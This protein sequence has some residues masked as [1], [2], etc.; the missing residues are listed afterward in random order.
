MQF[1]WKHIDDIL[2]KGFSIIDLL[3][4]ISYF[5]VTQIPMALPIAIGILAA[6]AAACVLVLVMRRRAP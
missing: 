5:A 3:E 4:L 6:V 1:L 2:G